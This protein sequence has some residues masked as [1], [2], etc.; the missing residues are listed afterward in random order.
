M[1]R[2]HKFLLAKP[3]KVTD[4]S[5]ESFPADVEIIPL[6]GHFFDMVGFKTLDGTVFI[7]DCL[8]SSETLNKYKI[9]F[10]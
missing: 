5:D 8:S 4:F 2:N 6:K 7:A 10:I 3:S 9:G 1:A